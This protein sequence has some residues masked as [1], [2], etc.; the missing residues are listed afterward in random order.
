MKL[1]NAVVLFS[2]FMDNHFYNTR[3]RCVQRTRLWIARNVNGL[4]WVDREVAIVS[5]REMARE[6]CR[7]SVDLF[8]QPALTCD[9]SIRL[10]ISIEEVYTLVG[11][12]GHKRGVWFNATC[13]PGGISTGIWPFF[14]I[15]RP[16]PHPQA[17]KK[18]QSPRE[19][20]SSVST[21]TQKGGQF[22][23]VYN[24]SRNRRFLN[25][26][27][28]AL[29]AS[30]AYVAEELSEIRKYFINLENQYEMINRIIMLWTTGS[31]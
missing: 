29:F 6:Y 16:I 5:W 18:R 25:N 21:C 26:A 23:L 9:L 27:P 31:Y 10:S 8:L 24:S 2:L 1:N 17:L 19:S 22:W 28:F 14:I 7:V 11:T 30:A 3:A 15:W 12:A 4:V 13:Y 20:T